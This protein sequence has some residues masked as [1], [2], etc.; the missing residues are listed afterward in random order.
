MSTVLLLFS[1]LLFDKYVSVPVS[2]VRFGILMVLLLKIQ[3]VWDV[4]LFLLFH[5][6]HSAMIFEVKQLTAT[7]IRM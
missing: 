6:D 7:C 5:R 2:C 4:T 3:V 1:F